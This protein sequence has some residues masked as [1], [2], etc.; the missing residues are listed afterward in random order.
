MA[1]IP[2]AVRQPLAEEKLVTNLKGDKGY[3]EATEPV[4]TT[5]VGYVTLT[6]DDGPSVHTEEILEVLAEKQARAIF[7]MVGEN[8]EKS[9]Q[10]ARQVAAAGHVIGNHSYSHVFMT[11]VSEEE[12][13]RQITRTNKIIEDA[14]GVTPRYFRP[15]YGAFNETTLL[16]AARQ[17][18][19][20]IMWSADPKDYAFNT[21]NAVYRATEPILSSRDILLLHDLKEATAQALPEIIDSIRSKNLQVTAQYE[22]KR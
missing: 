4:F 3:E 18:L 13:L 11:K 7:F 9:P 14:T 8:V 1:T 15:P 20:M 17:H 5:D 12:A 2:E 21:A 22:H 19:K 6:L 16:Q 10:L